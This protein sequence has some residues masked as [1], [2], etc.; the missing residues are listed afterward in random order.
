MAWRMVRT[1]RG[2]NN[3]V[4]VH[5]RDAEDTLKTSF[6]FQHRPYFYV[7]ENTKTDLLSQKGFEALGGE[8]VKKVFVRN[9]SDVPQAREKFDSHWEADVPY[10]RRFLIDKGIN[11]WFDLVGDEVVPAEEIEGPLRIGYLDIEV[12]SRTQ[13]GMPKAEKDP[14]TCVTI[15]SDGEYASFLLDDFGFVGGEDNWVVV[16]CPAEEK[17]LKCVVGVLEQ[18]NYDVLTGWN[19]EFDLGYLRKRCEVMG[20]E[21]DL[22]SSC[23]LDLL[24]AYRSLYRQKS[25]RLKDVVVAEG[26]AAELEPVVDYA[27][28][29]DNH[30]EELLL[31]NLRH[32]TWCYDL[33]QKHQ[34]VAYLWHLKEVV[35]LE[36]LKDI[37]YN[38]VLIDTAILRRTSW[39]LP[40]KEK[41]PRVPYEGAYVMRP[42]E[43]IL[44]NVAV[45][46]LSRFYPSIIMAERLDPLIIR[47]YK[48]EH[49]EMVDWE[50]YREY[51]K[52]H[53]TVILDFVA[54]MVEERKRLQAGQHAEKLAA[55]KGLLNSVYG[56]FALPSF[57][58]YTRE[59]P[60]RITEVA[61]GTIKAMIRQVEEWG[62]RVVASDTDSIAVVIDREQVSV[63]EGR[64]NGF[65]NGDYSV[66]LEHYFTSV[67]YT[68]KK[69]RAVGREED[70]RL[71]WTGFEFKRSDASELTKGLQEEL[72]GMLLDGERESA[73]EY[74][75]KKIEA[76]R[77]APLKELVVTR[78]L[79]R[80]LEEYKSHK[81]DYLKAIE[82]ATW[83]RV[84]AGD[85]VNT[86]PAVNY[87]F[88]VAVYQD[89][90]TLPY[91][92][93]VDYEVIVQ[94][95]VKQKVT[96]IL[97]MVGLDWKSVQGQGRLI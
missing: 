44:Q 8:K 15:G 10:A 13:D 87:P 89:E 19:V 73:I 75:R 96:G 37:H 24:T 33:D 29:W 74:L 48:R 43:G 23:E 91:P 80:E 68:G 70:G 49:G 34:V 94:K 30:R 39:V 84:G 83:L 60:E 20:V 77:S 54:E 11:S 18:E 65:L 95:Q 78:T 4:I 97:E 64:I 71:H 72:F 79:G 25:Y 88:G 76:V 90:S 7:E 31:R 69:K 1:H 53:R 5:A 55:I 2:K 92:M 61:R 46:D 93:E 47:D 81:A 56:V 42:P 63:L 12:Y 6:T 14:V 35:G 66:K 86:I 9:P 3:E 82:K 41:R 26:I 36:D 22:D 51:S 58:L 40:S 52:D 57:R 17:L 67:M 62:Y 38:S 28:L 16:R 59:I 50:I 45:W 21:L 85:S 32:V 27:D